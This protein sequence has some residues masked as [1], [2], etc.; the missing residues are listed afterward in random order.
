MSTETLEEGAVEEG[1]QRRMYGCPA[2][3][4]ALFFERDLSGG[5]EHP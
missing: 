4:E 1:D 2:Q 3:G 5:G